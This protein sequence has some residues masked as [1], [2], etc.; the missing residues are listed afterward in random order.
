M[1]AKKANESK[2]L[3]TC[4]NGIEDIETGVVWYLRDEPGG[5]LLI[6]QAVSG[7]EAARA[8]P[9]LRCG[10][11]EPVAARPRAASGAVVACGWSSGARTP[12]SRSARGRVV[13]RGTGADL[14][15]VA[16]KAL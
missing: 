3:M 14:T 1:W 5:G 8:W 4:R 15:V 6:G 2:P 16:M 11:W 7:M 9:G 12:S 10:T 13:M